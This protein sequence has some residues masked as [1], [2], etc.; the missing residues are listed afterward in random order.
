[1][2]NNLKAPPDSTWRSLVRRLGLGGQLSN[3]QNRFHIVYSGW[4]D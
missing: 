2:A 1:L 4:L 3:P